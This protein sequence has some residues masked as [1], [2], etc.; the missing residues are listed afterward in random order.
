MLLDANS[1]LTQQH[2][3]DLAGWAVEAAVSSL[4]CKPYGEKEPVTALRRAVMSRP[5]QLYDYAGAP[6]YIALV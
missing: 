3:L 5:W 4:I 6:I 1:G 2:V